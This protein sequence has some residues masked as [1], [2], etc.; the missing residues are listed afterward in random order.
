MM[1]HVKGVHYAQETGEN[2]T[3]DEDTPFPYPEL[4]YVRTTWGA[5]RKAHPNTDVYLGAPESDSDA[6]GETGE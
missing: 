3:S 6:A 2:L 5:W 4:P 1:L